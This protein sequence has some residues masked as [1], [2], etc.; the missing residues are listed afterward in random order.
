MGHYYSVKSGVMK[1][2]QIN[3]GIA[4]PLDDVAKKITQ[5]KLRVYIF[6]IIACI[7]SKPRRWTHSETV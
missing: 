2:Q 1:D 4:K 7:N 6:M 3:G 5:N